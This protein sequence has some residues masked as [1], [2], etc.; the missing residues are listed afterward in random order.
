[1][2]GI[3]DSSDGTSVNP[4]DSS[5]NTNLP[6]EAKHTPPDFNEQTNYVPVK[7]IITVGKSA[8]LPSKKTTLV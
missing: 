7:T 4:V 5:L 6:S 3:K 8:S 1:M 2:S